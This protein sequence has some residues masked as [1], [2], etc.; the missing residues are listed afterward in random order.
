MSKMIGIKIDDSSNLQDRFKTA[1]ERF[2]VTYAELLK[3]WLD[4]MDENPNQ[5]SLFPEREPLTK[6]DLDGIRNQIADLEY[7]LHRRG[8]FY[9][10]ISWLAGKF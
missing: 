3:F 1:A 5:L 10:I 7:S 8:V 6:G 4:K 9:R 2:G